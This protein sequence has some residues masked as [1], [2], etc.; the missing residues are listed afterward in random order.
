MVLQS[1]LFHLLSKRFGQP[2]RLLTSGPWSSELFAD[3]PDVGEIWQLHNRHMP[4][5]ASP[6]RWRLIRKLRNHDGLVYVSEDA[7]RHITK[8]RRLLKLAGIEQDRCVYITDQPSHNVHWVDRLLCFGTLTP[9]SVTSEEYPVLPEYLLPAPRLY[10]GAA[11]RLDRDEWLRTKGFSGK[12]IVL[13]Q[14]GNKQ[15]GRWRHDPKAD[16]KAWPVDRW[17]ELL[18]FIRAS[19]PQACLLLCGSSSES[20]LLRGISAASESCADI[21]THDLPLKRL[22]ALMEIAHS[23]VAVDTGPSH[24]AASVGCPLV[25]LYGSESPKVWSRRAAK[26]QPIIELGGPPDYAAAS[27]IPLDD[28][29]AAWRSICCAHELDSSVPGLNSIAAENR[30]G[31]PM[32]SL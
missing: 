17:I 25:V 19:L 8:T 30:T 20:T 3:D 6:Q 27:E 26:G 11:A 1:P 7:P 4:L 32:R 31:S 10:V 16:S 13:I 12:P 18:R 9:R 2:C 22:L 21:A 5:I 29:I 24:M 23:M 28:V 15:S 14:V